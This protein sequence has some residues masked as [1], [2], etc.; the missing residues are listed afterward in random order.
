MTKTAKETLEIREILSDL[1]GEVTAKSLFASYGLFHQKIMFGL[2][3]NNIFYLKAEGELAS[4]LESKGAA[5]YLAKQPQSPSTLNISSYYRLPK[6]ITSNKKLYK[7][8]LEESLQQIRDQKLSEQLAK[9]NRIKELPNLS[10]KHER[11]LGK[12]EIYDVHTFQILGAKNAYIRL[13]KKGISAGVGIFWAFYAA[14]ENKNINLI[15]TS[16]KENVLTRLNLA[17]AEAGL[18]QIK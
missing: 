18:R 3:Q 8:I 2:Y 14:L 15:T 13:K 12:V 17:L 6:E 9:K 5:S 4:Y 7:Q 10:I 16:E 1:I 11:M